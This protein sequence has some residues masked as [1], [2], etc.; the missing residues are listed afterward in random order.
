MSR[1]LSLLVTLS[2]GITILEYWKFNSKHVQDR[3]AFIAHNILRT[4][5]QDTGLHRCMISY[6][7]DCEAVWNLFYLETDV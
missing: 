4:A 2:F 5:S 7:T 6:L 1:V 3:A